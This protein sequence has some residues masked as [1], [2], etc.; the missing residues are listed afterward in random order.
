MS[1]ANFGSEVLDL[2]RNTEI[3]F[4]LVFAAKELFFFGFTFDWDKRENGI[5]AC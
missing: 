4:S 1:L 3:G 2:G 5:N